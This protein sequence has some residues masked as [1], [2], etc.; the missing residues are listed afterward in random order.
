MVR[1]FRSP[2]ALGALALLLLL[3]LAQ[4]HAQA[5]VPP[6]GHK[7]LC[8]PFIAPTPKPPRT[9][10]KWVCPPL[11]SNSA[12]MEHYGYYSSCWRPWPEPADLSHCP[13]PPGAVLPPPPP[14]RP[15]ADR[16]ADEELPPPTPLPKG[17]EK[18]PNL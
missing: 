4:P 8:P 15:S 3:G 14:P 9:M 18:K 16:Q 11:I 12:Q 2:L 6:C 1:L 17:E 13:C 5:Q 7:I 10:Y